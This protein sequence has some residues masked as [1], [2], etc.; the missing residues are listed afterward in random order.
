LL[1]GIDPRIQRRHRLRQ[2]ALH[3]RHHDRSAPRARD[4][5]RAS[6]PQSACHDA[7]CVLWHGSEMR[8]FGLHLKAR[9]SEIAR[10]QV[11]YAGT[12]HDGCRP[13]PPV[14]S[15]HPIE[16][17]R[18]EGTVRSGVLKSNRI[19]ELFPGTRATS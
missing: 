16:R 9:E 17:A 3:R 10:T 8:C 19:S 18:G 5:R 13:C 11:C 2:P 4:G 6:H 1:Q 15:G 12:G 14:Q 7:I